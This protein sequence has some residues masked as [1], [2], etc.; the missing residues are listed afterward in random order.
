[1]D[2]EDDMAELMEKPTP[3]AACECC[4]NAC[5][6]CVWDTYFEALAVWNAQQALIK[7]ENDS[8]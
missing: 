2:K 6:P 5:S 8:E 4:E 1:M 3:P 7:K